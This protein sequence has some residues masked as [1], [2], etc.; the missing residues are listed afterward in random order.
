MI[1][2]H[3]LAEGAQADP[4][5]IGMA[6]KNIGNSIIAGLIYTNSYGGRPGEWEMLERAQVA[7]SAALAP[8]TLPPP[9]ASNI[10]T[11]SI[12]AHQCMVLRTMAAEAKASQG[13]CHQQQLH[14]R[15][16]LRV[17]WPCKPYH[18]HQQARWRSLSS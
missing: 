18:L 8:A 9:A 2:L 13:H 7:S 5:T 15:V 10:A 3:F 11:T 1:D 14:S 6:A 12:Q 16:G 4:S 17:A